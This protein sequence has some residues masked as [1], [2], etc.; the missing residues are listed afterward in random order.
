MAE[1]AR[2][3]DLL[4]PDEATLR[5][6]VPHEVHPRTLDQLR[7][8]GLHDDEPRA[9]FESHGDHIVGIFVA[10]HSVRRENRVY[11]QEVNLVIAHDAVV[12]VRKTPDGG[13]PFRSEP[14]E[15][16]LRVA[17]ALPAGMLAYYIVDQIA[18]QYLDLVDELADEVDELE[19]GIETW[20]PE[21]IRTRIGDLRRD[22]LL[23]RRMLG[24]AREA[25][26]HIVSRRIDITG[27]EIFP[28][29]IE[30]NFA[31]AYD[32]LLRANDGL[33][34]IRDLVVG[35]RDYHQSKIAHEQNEVMKRLT[36]IAALL[37]FPT[38]LVGVYGQNFVHMPELKWRLGYLFSWGVIAVVTLGQLWWFRRKKWL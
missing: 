25:V 6:M 8:P 4:D 17:G 36:V 18:E 29:D 21:L 12:T 19:E 34:L 1:A 9:R 20:E 11:Y 14:L 23:A 2:W 24:P 30:L 31:D 33:E 5:R 28:R 26:N 7:A 35:A 13:L 37:L 16:T 15:E 22:I 10:P 38:F 32:K 3:I 27:G